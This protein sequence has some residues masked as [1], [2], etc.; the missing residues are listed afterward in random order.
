MK[1]LDDLKNQMSSL[2]WEK[3]GDPGSAKL[4]SDGNVVACYG[5]ATWINDVHDCLDRI[6]RAAVRAELERRGLLAPADPDGSDGG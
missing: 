3:G 4:D 6:E 1:A 2:G 5:G